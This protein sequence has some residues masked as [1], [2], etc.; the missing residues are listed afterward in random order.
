MYS[1]KKWLQILGC[2]NNSSLGKQEFEKQINCYFDEETYPKE[3]IAEWLLYNIGNCFEVVIHAEDTLLEV[4][5][6]NG[7]AKSAPLGENLRAPL[8]QFYDSYHEFDYEDFF[9]ISDGVLTLDESEEEM[10]VDYISDKTGFLV[11]TYSYSIEFVEEN[12][13]FDF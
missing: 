10:L 9:V 4:D 3:A 1:H 5:S 7:K 6:P 11:Q 12:M 8:I 2:I 13:D